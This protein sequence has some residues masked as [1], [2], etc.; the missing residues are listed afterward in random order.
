MSSTRKVTAKEVAEAAG[1]SMMTVSAVLGRGTAHNS[2]VS[3]ATRQRVLEAAKKLNY[4]PSAVAHGM[5][6]R[7]MNTLGVVLINPGARLQGDSYVCGLL[8][9]II[10]VANAAGQNTTLFTGQKWSDAAHSLPVFCDGRTDGLIILSPSQDSDIVPALL[11]VEVPFVLINGHSDDPRVSSVNIDNVAPMQALVGHVLQQGHRRIAFLPG[12]ASTQSSQER[13]E[14]YR[15]ALAAAGVPFDPSLV[16]SGY[17]AAQSGSER[18]R[19]LLALAPEQRPTALCCGSDQIALGARRALQEAGARVP[20][21]MSLTGFDDIP[22]AASML[23]PLTTVRHPFDALGRRAA[24]ILLEGIEAGTPLGAKELLP[25]EVVLR[26]SVA[27][28][29]GASAPP[30]IISHTTHQRRGS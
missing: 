17:Y 15:R 5:R 29:G 9:G 27:P 21:E 11:Q 8:D 14:G 1:V 13:H 6:R 7:R 19:H 3:E 18:T 26:D 25:T 23:P 10:A 24:E 20:E 4:F 28:P 2:R 22:E 16:L 30:E 12:R